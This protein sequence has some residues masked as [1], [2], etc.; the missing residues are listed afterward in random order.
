MPPFRRDLSGNQGVQRGAFVLA[1]ASPPLPHHREGV[2]SSSF[3]SKISSPS[4]VPGSVRWTTI[5]PTG[6][7]D[8]VRDR[9]FPQPR[10]DPS[11]PFENPLV[12]SPPSICTPQSLHTVR[13]PPASNSL[14]LAPPS[15]RASDPFETSSG[16]PGSSHG[17]W[18][19]I[20]CSI[21]ETTCCS[22][23]TDVHVFFFCF[24]SR[25]RSARRLDA[26]RRA[27]A[28]AKADQHDAVFTCAWWEVP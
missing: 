18:G 22:S 12:S 20:T 4:T 27:N 9:R 1:N 21:H 19:P 10:T 24:H 7:G 26:R 28:S 23:P 3:V 14:V 16:R 25:T 11:T 6:T 13:S 2:P 8:Q 15:D 5:G 17:S